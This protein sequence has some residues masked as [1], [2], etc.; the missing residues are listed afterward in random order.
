MKEKTCIS[1]DKE[2]RIEVLQECQV[3]RVKKKGSDRQMRQLLK[4]G[5]Y[6]RI[7]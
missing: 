5:V 1:N 7:V 6:R 3:K 4:K 2:V